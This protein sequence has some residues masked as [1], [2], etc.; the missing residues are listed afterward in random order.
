[1]NKTYIQLQ[2]AIQENGG[3]VCEQVPDAFFLEEETKDPN[4]N[5]KIKVAK[6]ICAECPVR[7]LCLEYALEESEVFGIWGGLTY[8]ERN[9]LKRGRIT[10]AGIH[11]SDTWG[12]EGIRVRLAS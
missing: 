12:P 7:M 2:E 11:R 9:R 3:V 8:P 10:G 6:A 5:Q 4:R 1:M